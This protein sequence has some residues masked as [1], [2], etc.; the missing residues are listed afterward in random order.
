MD[1]LLELGRDHSTG[2]LVG[3]TTGALA[4]IGI[5]LVTWLRR[6]PPGPPPGS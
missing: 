4:V 5:A 3:V 2:V 1:Q 6:P